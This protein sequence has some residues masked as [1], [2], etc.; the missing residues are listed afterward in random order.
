MSA[1][2]LI[3]SL[4]GNTTYGLPLKDGGVLLVDA[5]PDVPEEGTWDLALQQ[6]AVHG[7]RASDVRAVLLTH[8][9]LDHSGLAWRWVAEGAQIFVGEDDLNAVASGQA[10]N[11]RLSK[12]RVQ[13]LI[14]HGCPDRLAGNFAQPTRRRPPEYRWKPCPREALSAIRD[15]AEFDLDEGKA[16]RVVSA[17]GHTLGNLV[18]FVEASGDLYSGDTLLPS[19]VPTPGLHFP[20][21]TDVEGGSFSGERWPS[22]PS[23]I[24]S[25]SQLRRLNVKRVLPGHGGPVEGQ[26]MERLF[27]R[28]ERHHAR[29][30]AKV[31]QLLEEKSDTAYG[32]VFRLFPHLPEL[33]IAQAMTE[34]IGQLD[35][36]VANG[37]VIAEDE[38]GVWVHRI[39]D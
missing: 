14:E 34:V 16:L 4:S 22:L 10:W 35:V 25:V 13:A 12:V 31:R 23:F 33:R 28:F 32:L 11:E 37:D 9:H 8:W 39:L 5:G 3:L 1:E 19:T 30:S 27:E 20:D 7:F 38:G 21:S 18:A 2:P 29:R 26:D 15:G 24:R 36:L 17:P 6:L